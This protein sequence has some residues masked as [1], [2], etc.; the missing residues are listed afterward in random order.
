[1]LSQFK[2]RMFWHLAINILPK[3]PAANRTKTLG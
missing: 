3:E 2:F 1:M